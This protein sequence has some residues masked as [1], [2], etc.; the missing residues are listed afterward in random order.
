MQDGVVSTCILFLTVGYTDLAQTPA[1]INKKGATFINFGISSS[2][3][4]I[5]GSHESQ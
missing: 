1:I 2:I 3:A 4:T 5:S